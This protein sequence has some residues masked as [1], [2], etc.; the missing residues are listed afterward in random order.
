MVRRFLG[1]MAAL[2]LV[3]SV[4]FAD[5]VWPENTEGQK[6]LKTYMENVNRFLTEQGESP[7]NSLFEAYSGF[8][9]FGI[10]DQPDAETPETVEITA[11]LYANT[12]NSVE[13]RVSDLQRFPKIAAA[14]IRALTPETV[15]MEEALKDP[16]ERAN[17]AQKS[18]ETTF[19][20][21]IVELNGTVPYVYYAYYPNQHSDGVNWMQVTIIFPLEGYWDGTRILV[22]EEEASG[23]DKSQTSEEDFDEDYAGYTYED[24]YTHLEIFTTA[25]PEPDSAAGVIESM[26]DY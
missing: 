20:D 22:A 26:K 23:S 18:P 9:V 25:T 4:A 12:V 13:V 10:T 3:L 17:R 7:V 21:E 16:T 11:N 8:E 6:L 5:V 19:E 1:V 2:V 15:S 24:D 14:F